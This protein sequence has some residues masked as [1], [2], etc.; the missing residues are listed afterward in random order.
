MLKSFLG[1]ILWR[2]IGSSGFMPPFV[3]FR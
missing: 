1:K 2:H 3:I